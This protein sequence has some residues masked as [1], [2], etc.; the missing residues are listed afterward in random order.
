MDPTCPRCGSDAAVTRTTEADGT[1]YT[2][3]FSHDGE[4]PVSWLVRSRSRPARAPVADG[5]AGARTPRKPAAPRARRP[6]AESRADEPAR[7]ASVRLTVNERGIAAVVDEVTRRGGHARVEQD[8]NKREVVVTGNGNA[9]GDGDSDTGGDTDSDS[10][11]DTG[12]KGNGEVRLVVR[13]RTA[14]T[15]Q[16][17]ASYG[18]PRAEEEHP[19][20]FWVLVHLASG[21][22]FCYVIPEWWIRNDISEKHDDYLRSSGGTR[23]VSPDSDHH[24]IGTD[25]VA[26]WLDRWDQLQVLS[27]RD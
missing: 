9:N 2:C 8:G 22:A 6:A 18:E 27:A 13:A 20:T 10:D 21:K 17:K 5:S 12:G 19:T 23:P 4:G 26:Q 1:R 25:R 24:A 15:W 3:R 16:T 14:G 11:G 7:T